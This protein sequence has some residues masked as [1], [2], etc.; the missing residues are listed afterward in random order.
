MSRSDS[1]LCPHFGECGGCASQ[2]VPYAEQLARKQRLLEEMFRE[3]WPGEIPVAASPSVW[4][5][6]NKVDFNF[7]RKRYDE[8]PPPGTK[9]DTVLGFNRKGKWYW[10][11]DIENC[12]IAP[13]RADELLGAV[14]AWA[15]REGL[16]AY[17]DRTKE[18]SLRIL[19]LREGRRT[20]QHMV[21]LITRPGAIP[22]ESFADAVRSVYPEASVQH[23]EY[24]GEAQGKFA[25][26]WR[27]IRG[28]ET[29]SEELQVPDAEG[30]RNINFRISPFSF[31]QTNTLAAEV[32]Y[33]KIRAWVRKAAPDVLYDLYGG[34]GSIAFAC[35]DLVKVVRSVENVTEA[36]LDGEANAKANA[37]ENVFFTAADV[38]AYLLNV[39][40][41]GGMEP[42][43][44]AVVDPPRA[45]MHPK[46]L[47]RLIACAPKDLLYVSCKPEMLAQEMP[48][49]L[50]HYEL[51]GFSA[52]DMFP[53]TPHVEAL[54]TFRR[55]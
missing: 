49:L 41:D 26:T 11:L 24:T 3:F 17:D 15:K 35:A 40:N 18:G 32:L 22:A 8:P 54:A 30:T 42:K 37:I 52:V 5:Y 1:I 29:I 14:R 10:P 25:D 46:A 48:E 53:H 2:D 23:G 9:R 19:L 55:T 20:G 13:A 45:G 43:A 6:R 44:A 12:L 34:T 36:A 38:R 28:L 4:H 50:K 51:T 7:A 47:K 31:F 21:M 16:E 39:A 33:G 27:V